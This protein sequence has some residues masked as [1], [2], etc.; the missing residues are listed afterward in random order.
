MQAA[1]LL[2]GE[3]ENHMVLAEQVIVAIRGAARAEGVGSQ[4]KA[5]G[6]L[7]QYVP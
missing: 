5:A 6:R 4:G 3:P 2:F 7:P 1:G